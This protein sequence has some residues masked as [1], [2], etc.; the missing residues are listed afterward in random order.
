MSLIDIGSGSQ[1]RNPRLNNPD[2]V[3]TRMAHNTQGN[4]YRTVGSGVIPRMVFK[5]GLII[6]YD[7]NNLASSVYGY[8]PE[9]SAVPFFLVAA[10][11]YDVFV[12]LLEIDPPII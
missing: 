7:E 6:T 2:G 9:V 5:Q 10:P 12:D 4:T 11:G 8:I 3:A 1:R